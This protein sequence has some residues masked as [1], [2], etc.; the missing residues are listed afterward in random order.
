M[1]HEVRLERASN[2]ST[3]GRDGCAAWRGP[4]LA[5]L[6]TNGVRD[7]RVQPSQVAKMMVRLK[8]A[9]ASKNPVL[10]GVPFDAGHGLGS[11]R[12][13]VDEQRADEHAFVL[14]RTGARGFQVKR[15]PGRGSLPGAP[16]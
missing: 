2:L 16:D 13:Q 15:L 9:T 1:I 11:T 14:W 6:L 4:Y 8:K 12:T 10:F 3:S 5:V 7:P